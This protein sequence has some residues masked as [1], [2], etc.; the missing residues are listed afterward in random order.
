MEQ[1]A[2]EKSQQRG[3]RWWAPPETGQAG[4]LLPEAATATTRPPLGLLEGV[5]GHRMQCCTPL[6]L[7]P[8]PSKVWPKAEPSTWP[9]FFFKGRTCGIW[10]FPG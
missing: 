10:T 9:L 8:K 1:E 3:S 4:P 2:G 5:V 6:A 7:G